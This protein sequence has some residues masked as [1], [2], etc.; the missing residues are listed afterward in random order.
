[1]FNNSLPE[2]VL[3]RAIVTAGVAAGSAN[4]AALPRAR[5]GRSRGLNEPRPRKR[6]VRRIGREQ[7]GPLQ[8]GEAE[9]APHDREHDAHN[10][11]VSHGSTPMVVAPRLMK[12]T[13]RCIGVREGTRLLVINAA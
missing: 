3:H 4:W 2:T 1:M 10:A 7:A 12:A 13:H 9:R 6:S 11:E 8:N 5:S